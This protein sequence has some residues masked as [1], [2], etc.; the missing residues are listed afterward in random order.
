MWVYCIT[1]A[2]WYYSGTTLSSAYILL[3]TYSTSLTRYTQTKR[4]FV[5]CSGTATQN[6]SNSS[7]GILK[8]VT[9]KSQQSCIQYNILIQI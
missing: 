3:Y 9:D 8:V 2:G 7:L 5:I 1:C 4:Y 6:S